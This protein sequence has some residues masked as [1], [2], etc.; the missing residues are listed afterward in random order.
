MY[1]VSKERLPV[2]FCRDH[3]LEPN[4]LVFFHLTLHAAKFVSAKLLGTMS[5]NYF[6]EIRDA[7]KRIHTGRRIT[8]NLGCLQF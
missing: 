2:L 3:L 8:Y 7:A 4:N 1:C 5:T 6:E